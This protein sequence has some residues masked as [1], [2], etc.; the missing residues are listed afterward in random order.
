LYHVGEGFDIDLLS[1]EDP[2]EY[3]NDNQ[4]HLFKH[5]YSKNDILDIWYSDPLFFPARDGGS[6]DWLMVGRPPGEEPLVVPLAPS[7]KDD[8]RKCRPIGVYKAS[9]DVLSQYLQAQG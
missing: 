5:A 9:G 4:P 2:F 6:A 7:R 8:Y 1:L 3:D